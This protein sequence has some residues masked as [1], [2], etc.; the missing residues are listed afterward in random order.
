M[1]SAQ[2]DAVHTALSQR[3]DTQS[4]PALHA[5]PGAQRLGH[6]SPQST[7]G[8]RPFCTPSLQLEPFARQLGPGHSDSSHVLRSS[9][10]EHAAVQPPLMQRCEALHSASAPQ[11]LGPM[12][13]V[14]RPAPASSAGSTELATRVGSKSSCV[15]VQ[16]THS[17]ASQSERASVRRLSVPFT[18]MVEPFTRV[19]NV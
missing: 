6:A 17:S 9:P 11:Q 16:A 18:R 2:E 5:L 4:A 1:P 12:Q 3:P 14:P 19:S 15:K 13:P 7:A 10:A 8:S